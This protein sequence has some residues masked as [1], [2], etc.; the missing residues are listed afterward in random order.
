MTDEDILQLTKNYFEESFVEYDEDDNEVTDFIASKE[1]LLKFA[2]YLL[3][4]GFSE[5]HKDGYILGAEDEQKHPENSW[6]E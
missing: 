4:C 6:S 5:G 3:D 1:N 2:R